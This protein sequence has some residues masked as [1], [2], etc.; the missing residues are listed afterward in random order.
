M[1]CGVPHA[2]QTQTGRPMAEDCLAF[3]IGRG[4]LEELFIQI[5]MDAGFST[6]KSMS[7][8][9]TEDALRVCLRQHGLADAAMAACRQ[10]ARQHPV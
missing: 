1:P 3:G 9:M 2:A 7:E 5:T 4:T 10:H 6:M 8:P